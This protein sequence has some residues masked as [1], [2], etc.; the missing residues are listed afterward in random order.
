MARASASK[1]DPKTDGNTIDHWSLSLLVGRAM[2]TPSTRS[3]PAGDVTEVD[4]R[5]A[6]F[7]GTE[8]VSASV[9]GPSAIFVGIDEGTEILVIGT[10]RRRFFRSGGATVSRTEIVAT[11]VIKRSNRR[12]TS[13]ALTDVSTFL[14]SSADQ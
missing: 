12:G 2:G 6:Q 1:T 13:R 9:V 3:T 11:Q 10:T 7:R 4:V 5:S 8:V 14:T